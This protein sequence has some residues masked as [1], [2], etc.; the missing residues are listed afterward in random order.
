[1]ARASTLLPVPLSPSRST[2]A[3]LSAALKA[4]SSLSQYGGTV[5]KTDPGAGATGVAG[6]KV[7][8]E[9]SN[10]VT[11]PSVTGQPAQQAQQTLQ[12]MGLQVQIQAVANDPNGQVFVESPSAG[13][14]VA[15]GSTVTLGVFP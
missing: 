8:V 7:G 11:L 14:L 13:A 4:I 2:V 5:I 1:M 6:N 3:S 10:A 15:P 12:G 9:V